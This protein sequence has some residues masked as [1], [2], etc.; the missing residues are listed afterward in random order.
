MN[1]YNQC[2]DDQGQL[3]IRLEAAAIEGIF[4]LAEVGALTLQWS[5]VLDYENSL[6][7]HED[8]KEGV[9]LLSRLCAD[10][11]GASSGILVLA[12]HLMESRK[13]KPRDALHLAAAE[14][15]GC[16]Y[17]ITCDDALIRGLERV[18]RTPEMRVKAVNPVEFIRAE[19][20]KYGQS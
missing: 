10:T 3:R 4:S 2:F 6:N 15:A 16:D 7:L 8:R 18:P 13:I 12:R 11:I 1:I 14:M 17:F 5:F 9:E 20:E 19:G